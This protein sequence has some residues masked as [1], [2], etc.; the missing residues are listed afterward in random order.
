[1]SLTR[2][3]TLSPEEMEKLIERLA[4]HG[5][6]ISMTDPRV[7]SVQNWIFAAIGGVLLLLGGWVGQSI[8]ELN[9]NM[10]AVLAQNA[11]GQRVNDA[12]DTRL[13]IYDGRLRAV[14]RQ[15]K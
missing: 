1:M 13:D 10:A 3:P 9:K 6:R 5:A 11:Y 15:L 14:E 7:T 2:P 4:N 8:S 12:Q